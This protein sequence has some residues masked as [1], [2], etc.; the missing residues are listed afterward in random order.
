MARLSIDRHSYITVSCPLSRDLTL[1]PPGNL[2]L[3]HV[4]YIIIP[5]F[6]NPPL[7]VG[8]NA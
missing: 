6:E 5:T 3:Y 2:K 7:P 1:K 4:S 8:G